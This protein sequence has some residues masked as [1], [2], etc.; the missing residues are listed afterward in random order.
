MDEPQLIL[1]YPRLW[2]TLMRVG[3]KQRFSEIREQFFMKLAYDGP[4][5]YRGSGALK[6]ILDKSYLFFVK[7]S[8]KN[9]LNVND[10]E[11]FKHHTFVSNDGGIQIEYFAFCDRD[12]ISYTLLNDEGTMI[13]RIGTDNSISV[14]GGFIARKEVI[15]NE[16]PENDPDRKSFDEVV[17]TANIILIAEK[18][19]D[20]KNG[21]YPS[22]I[23]RHLAG[24]CL[25]EIMKIFGKDGNGYDGMKVPLIWTDE[26]QI[27]WMADLHYLYLILNDA[28]EDVKTFIKFV[29]MFL[30]Y[31][32]DGVTKE[33]NPIQECRIPKTTNPN[34]KP[35]VTYR[36]LNPIDRF[37]DYVDGMY[38]ET[39]REAFQEI[40]SSLMS[41]YEDYDKFLDE[42]KMA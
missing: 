7:P 24:V 11:R 23:K 35:K 14:H 36:T 34:S 28:S 5:I 16:L 2:K 18:S 42:I 25:Y 40:L 1:D 17:N 8:F 9:F 20:I 27:Q 39:M 33:Q 37:E 21:D 26:Q 12:R 13:T 3:L 10:D 32:S 6:Q 15:N 19:E 4:S 41:V 29:E 38:D 31:E 30:M 22:V